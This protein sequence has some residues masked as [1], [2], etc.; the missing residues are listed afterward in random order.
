[1]GVNFEACEFSQSVKIT[2]GFLAGKNELIRVVLLLFFLFFFKA[3]GCG[4]ELW[5]DFGFR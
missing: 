2:K 5:H 1:M 4:V 3:A